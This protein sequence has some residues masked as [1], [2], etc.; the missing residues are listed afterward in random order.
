MSHPY[1]DIPGDQYTAKELEQMEN[2]DGAVEV[3]FQLCIVTEQ[4]YEGLIFPSARWAEFH[5]EV[6][7]LERKHHELLQILKW[8]EYQGIIRSNSN[9]RQASK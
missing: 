9:G 3:G 5:A 8:F 1:L 6:G 2:E 7:E 4:L